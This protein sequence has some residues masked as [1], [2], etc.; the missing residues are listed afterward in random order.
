MTGRLRPRSHPLLGPA[1]GP[2]ERLLAPLS[3][4]QVG[5]CRPPPSFDMELTMPTAWNPLSLSH[6]ERSF[7]QARRVHRAPTLWRLISETLVEAQAMSRDAR[8]RYPFIGS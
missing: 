4:T 7:R 1:I 6:P 3:R 5:G 2:P 8:R